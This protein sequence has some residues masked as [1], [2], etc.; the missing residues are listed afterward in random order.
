[1]ASEREI[2]TKPYVP[3]I[4]KALDELKPTSVLAKKIPT[5]PFATSL[6]R[7]ET[8]ALHLAMFA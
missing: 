6:T 8:V 7:D 5:A 3:R 2:E 1:M 4:A